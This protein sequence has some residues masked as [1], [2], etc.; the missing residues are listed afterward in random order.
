MKRALVVALLILASTGG[1]ARMAPPGHADDIAVSFRIDGNGF[2]HG[3]GM[4]QYG[5]KGQ[6][7][8]GRSAAA[9]LGHYYQGTAVARAPVPAGIR[10]GLLQ[11]AGQATIASAGGLFGSDGTL[12]F[13]WG[14]GTRLVRPGESWQ[15][16]TAGGGWQL[17]A[18][19]APQTEVFGGWLRLE[20]QARNSLVSVAETGHRYRWGAIDFVHRPDPT[21]DAVVETSYEAYLYGLGEMP[22]S[23]S[24]AA[25]QAQAIAGRTYALDKARRSGDWRLGCACTVFS[26]VADQAYIGYDKEGGP[27]GDRWVQAVNTTAGLAVLSGGVPIQ[28]LYSSSSGGHTENNEVV[29]AGS[30]LPYLRGVPDPWDSNP[31]NPNSSWSVSYSQN[32]LSAALDAGGVGVGKVVDITAVPPF[33]VSGRPGQVINASQGGVTISGTSGTRR[34]SGSQLRS[35]LRLKSGL[36][37]LNVF[38]T[39]QPTGA[40]GRIHG[41]YNGDRKEDVAAFYNYGNGVTGIITW[42]ANTAGT[43]F[44]APVLSWS[45]CAGCWEW[46]RTR[47][48]AGDFNGDGKDEIGAFYNYG[49][50]TTGLFT[51]SFDNAGAVVAARPFVSCGGCFEW[52]RIKQ[53]AGDFNGDQRDDVG[54]FYNY[55]GGTTGLFTF[56]FDNAGAVVAARPFVSCGGCFEWERAKPI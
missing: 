56:S 5:A 43:G 24:L 41:D 47:A 37:R 49:G 35:A 6:A 14:T 7:D 9:I 11:G 51:F 52:E 4:S 2:G 45:S 40:L 39:V 15:V 25:L 38:R 48:V 54:A 27:S 3:V 13:R 18:N 17:F 33:G 22:S 12:E 26:T 36:F 55:G 19:G 46:E 28:A 53:V 32:Q 30:A 23:W 50:G 34:V 29:F 8:A 16:R 10:V 21:F 31:S 1:A 42:Y 20:F 44:V